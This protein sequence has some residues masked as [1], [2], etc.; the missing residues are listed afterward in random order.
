MELYSGAVLKYNVKPNDVAAP[1]SA[2]HSP[3]FP[4]ATSPASRTTPPARVRVP[5]GEGHERPAC[6]HACTPVW[7]EVRTADPKMQVR[8]GS[9]GVMGCTHPPPQAL[10]CLV[11]TT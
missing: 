10:A 3:T 9:S 5:S 2:P 1:Q 7:I 4:L 8:A 11:A 6:M